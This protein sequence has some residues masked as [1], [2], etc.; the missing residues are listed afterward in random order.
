MTKSQEIQKSSP[1]NKTLASPE[2]IYYEM[3]QNIR[4]EIEGSEGGKSIRKFAID[5]GL[6]HSNL[7]RL[8]N[9]CEAGKTPDRA[10]SVS[11]FFRICEILN[12]SHPCFF[13]DV[14]TFPSGMNVSVLDL[15]RLQMHMG[16]FNTLVLQLSR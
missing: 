6:S 14:E 9:G 1:T 13:P 5:N 2:W 7:Y 15:I 16:L 8:F 11:L 12:F 10:M 4:L 3:L